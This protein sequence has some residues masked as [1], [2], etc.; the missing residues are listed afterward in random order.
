LT[1][2]QGN[3]V[4][5]FLATDAIVALSVYG[6]TGEVGAGTYPREPVLPPNPNQPAPPA[7]RVLSL[8]GATN[9]LTIEDNRTY[10]LRLDSGTPISDFTIQSDE[11]RRPYLLLESADGDA[12][13]LVAAGGAAGPGRF[14]LDGI[15]AAS[16]SG[17]GDFVVER[18]QA[19]TAEDDDWDEIVITSCT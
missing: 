9:P 3:S 16:L 2:G 1:V 11:Q 18:A 7:N 10:R 12:A 4:T 14:N 17:S 15:W 13:N 6:F 8:V 19:A 5:T